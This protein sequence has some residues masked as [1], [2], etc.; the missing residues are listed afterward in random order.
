MLTVPYREIIRGNVNKL[1]QFGSLL[2]KKLNQNAE[3]SVKTSQW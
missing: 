3:C 2:N 1:R